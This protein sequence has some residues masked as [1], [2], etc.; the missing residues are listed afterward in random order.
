MKYFANPVKYQLKRNLP[1]RIM[2]CH[3]KGNQY[4]YEIPFDS[5]MTFRTFLD[6]FSDDYFS[7]RSHHDYEIFRNKEYL[8]LDEIIQDYNLKEPFQI[9][10]FNI[11]KENIKEKQNKTKL[12]NYGNLNETEVE[13]L[14]KEFDYNVSS[15]LKNNFFNYLIKNLNNNKIS[16]DIIDQNSNVEF[17]LG[18][19]LIEE[20]ET[21]TIISKI[22]KKIPDSI[23]SRSHFKDKSSQKAFLIQILSP[24]LDIKKD[25]NLILDFDGSFKGISTNE[26]ETDLIIKNQK[27]TILLPIHIIA[28]VQNDD[29]F[30]ENR[31][32]YLT[33]S[34]KSF[35]PL[36]V[37]DFNNLSKED[38][39]ALEK[40]IINDS[41]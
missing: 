4:T 23:D 34:Y 39:K 1:K 13:E 25:S 17:P 19:P 24:I 10:D 33:Q 5:P 29:R 31:I 9:F 20:E 38:I 6:K 18:T 30:I 8:L 32:K 27:E 16:K 12:L 35:N 36:K 22:F 7:G 14:E 3:Y 15:S 2:N 11:S 41:K 37:L 26:V 21:T 28:S 40:I